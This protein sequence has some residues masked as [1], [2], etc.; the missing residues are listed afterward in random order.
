MKTSVLKVLSSIGPEV[1]KI[2]VVDDACPEQ[3]GK[4]AQ[5]QCR[6]PR[7]K[8]LFHTQNLGVGGATLTG[9]SQA[10]S[11]GADIVVK[12]D[13]DDQMDPRKIPLLIRP[14]LD[15]RADYAKG[16]RFFAPEFLSS[17]PKMR[18]IGNA[19]LS[20]LTKISCGYWRIMDPTNGFVALQAKLLPLLP[21]SKVD[22]TYF[23]ETDMLFRLNTLRAV[24][25]DVP[26][27]AQ[28]GGE[29]S[30]LRISRI[31]F[32]FSFKH[33][34]CFFKRVF[35][36]YFLRDFNLGSVQLVAGIGLPVFGVCFGAAAWWENA[37]LG[38]VSPFGTVM[39]AALP[40]LI[41]FQ[42][43]LSA[44]NYD[45]LNEPRSPLFRQL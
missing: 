4:W 8:V 32:P 5:S 14:L 16:N 13:G 24:V 6:D 28:Y 21:P 23:F 43:L 7:V 41:G 30:N 33:L 11:D 26:M 40:I 37:H 39:I 35:Y 44:I 29:N 27:P 45:I 12:L 1:D 25:E 19:A 2:Y 10:Y 38:R 18:L 17:M 9:F 36:N 34:R 15:G 31:L 3:S 22:K 42:M 20:F